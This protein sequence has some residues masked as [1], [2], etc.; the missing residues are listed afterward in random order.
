[1]TIDSPCKSGYSKEMNASFEK[2]KFNK[3]WLWK[4]I[5]DTVVNTIRD[6]EES[7]TVWW[8]GAIPRE[9]EKAFLSRCYANDEHYNYHKKNLIFSSGSDQGQSENALKTLE[10][11]KNLLW[12]HS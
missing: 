3:S 7:G 12:I 4:E 5:L 10:N 6:N 8:G 9:H 11:N 2:K 1:M